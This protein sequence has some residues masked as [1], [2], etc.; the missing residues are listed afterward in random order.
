MKTLYFVSNNLMS[1]VNVIYPRTTSFKELREKTLLSS[2]GEEI[3]RNL[4]KDINLTGIQAIYSSP[5]ISAIET[6]KYIA[7]DKKLDIY[8]DNRLSERIVGELGCNEYRFLKGMQEHDFTY[9]LENG[10]SLEEVKA[11]MVSCIKEILMSE[12]EKILVV[13]H[14]IALL[15]LFL[16]WCHKDFNLEDRL[17]L[18]YHEDVIFDG[19]FHDYDLIEVQYDDLK[20]CSIK[21]LR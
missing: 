4:G 5:Y 12:E 14:N 20:V 19:V 15:S 8:L 10:E 17:I 13:T 7:E 1:G 21:R 11:R 6:S 16:T 2:K 18:D 9:K 3:A